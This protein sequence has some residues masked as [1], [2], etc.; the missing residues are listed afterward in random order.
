MSKGQYE[1]VWSYIESGKEEGAEVVVG[2]EKRAGKGYYVDP[3][4]QSTPKYV[5]FIQ[6][7][8]IVVKFSLTFAR[9]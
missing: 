4:S 5:I 3:T 1:R 8:R 2:G 7:L 6:S 9:V